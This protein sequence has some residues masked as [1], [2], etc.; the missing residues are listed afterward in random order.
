MLDKKVS[1]DAGKKVG[2]DAGKKVSRD[3]GK[4]VSRASGEKVSTV[5]PMLHIKTLIIIINYIYRVL[6][7]L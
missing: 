3:A 1:R 7:R 4:K 6:Y 2:R 5:R